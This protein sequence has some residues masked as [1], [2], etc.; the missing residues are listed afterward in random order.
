MNW[1]ND[2]DGAVFRLLVKNNCDF[3][4]EYVI[5]LNL[6][7]DHWPLTEE[8]ISNIKALFP[9]VE[10]VNPGPG[11]DIGNG[12]NIGFLQFQVVNKLSYE[13]I[14][15]LQASVTKSI[16]KYKG[17]CDSWGVGGGD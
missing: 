7:F 9:N 1:P 14:T 12:V 6:D 2:A 3:E 13:Y 5:D 11:Q 16:S 15:E 10:I 17:W 4:K 8:E